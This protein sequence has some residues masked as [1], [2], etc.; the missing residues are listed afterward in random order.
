M[1]Y[2]ANL[3]EDEEKDVE[4]K[5]HEKTPEEESTEKKGIK[6]SC[7]ELYDPISMINIVEKNR[8]VKRDDILIY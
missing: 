4:K 2:L 6:N 8:R 5:H 7:Y 1:F 3:N